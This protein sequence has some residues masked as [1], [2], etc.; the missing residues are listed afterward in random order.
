MKKAKSKLAQPSEKLPGSKS[1]EFKPKPDEIRRKAHEIY[2]ARGGGQG[3]ELDDWLM[4]ER[5]MR[6]DHAKGL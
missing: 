3:L 2:L 4:A 5:E 6:Q 1:P